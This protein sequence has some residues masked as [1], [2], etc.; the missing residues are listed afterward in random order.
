L[1]NLNCQNKE[2]KYKKP[3]DF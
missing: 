1:Q 2:T 3:A